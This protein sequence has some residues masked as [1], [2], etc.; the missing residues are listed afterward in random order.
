MAASGL[1]RLDVRP[2]L[3]L[4]GEQR[5]RAGRRVVRGRWD[6]RAGTSR[7][8]TGAVK[9]TADA[10]VAPQP[11]AARGAALPAPSARDAGH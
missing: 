2:G 9:H 3:R 10:S 11:S 7:G 5:L 1:R 8:A 4:H 6:G